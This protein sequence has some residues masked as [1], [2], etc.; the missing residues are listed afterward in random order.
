ME[1]KTAA[2]RVDII[3]LKMVREKSVLYGNR[4]ISSC[5]DAFH[6]IRDFLQDSDREKFV[7]VYLNTKNEPT[8]IHTVSIGTLNSAL[9]HVREVFKGAILSNSA[10][11]ILSHNHPS[12]NNVYPSSE[13]LQITERL[14]E[15]GKIIGIE[16]LDHLIIGSTGSFYSFKQ[17]GKM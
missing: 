3:S 11:M 13:D 5:E 1:K 7:V 15:A 16:I 10:S 2:K 12:G 14:V 17:D 6:L 9:V 8:A 4:K